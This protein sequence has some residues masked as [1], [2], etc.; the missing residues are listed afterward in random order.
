MRST[1]S[2]GGAIVTNLIPLEP[3]NGSGPTKNFYVSVCCTSDYCKMVF[4][5]SHKY[6]KV[7]NNYY[8]VKTNS[9]YG[10][11]I[12]QILFTESEDEI[13]DGRHITGLSGNLSLD[14]IRKI[15]KI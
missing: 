5:K 3:L 14:Q 8:L 11:K 13:K 10:N 2:D 9:K 12:V 4:E 15:C 1:S 7:G 6:K